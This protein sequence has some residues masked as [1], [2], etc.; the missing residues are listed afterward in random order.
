[1]VGMVG[2][3]LVFLVRVTL[4]AGGVW[5]GVAE[6]SWGRSAPEG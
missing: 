4:H 3:V 5:Y 1:M 2:V 6:A